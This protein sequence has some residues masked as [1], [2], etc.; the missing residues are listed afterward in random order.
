MAESGKAKMPIVVSAKADEATRQS[1][2]ELAAQL[3]R[4]TGATFITIPGDGTTGI[5]VGTATDFPALV[6]AAGLRAA[7]V[8][9]P[10]AYVLHSHREGIHLVGA[11]AA[12]VRHAVWDLLYIVGFRQFFPGQHWEVVPSSPT[13]RIVVDVRRGPA[14]L[15]RRIVYGFGT[16]PELKDSYQN[17]TI[18]NRMDG[19]VSMTTG[20]AYGQI[21]RANKAQFGQ[22]PEWLGLVGGERKSSKF[23]I[24]N[25][26]LRKFISEFEARRV[27]EN[28]SIES[29]SMEPSDGGGWCECDA[30]AKLGTISDRALLLANDVA[31]AI[32]KIRPGIRV[33]LYAYN[34]HSPPPKTVRAHPS[35]VVSVATAFLRGGNT[36]KSLL[37]SWAAKG[38]SQFG[39][40]EYY[41]VNTWDRDLP[42]HARGGNLKYLAE[43]IPTFYK[44]GARFMTA[45]AGANWGPN[46]LGYYIAAR[47]LWDPAEAARMNEL[48]QDF[49]S[50]AFGP[51]QKAMTS[52]YR[53]LDGSHL[54]PV[55]T[56]LVGRLYRS[57]DEAFHMTQDPAIRARLDDLLLY[58]RYVELFRAYGA[59]RG[60]D[61]QIAFEAL[62]RFSYRI[63]G[64]QMVHSLALYRDLVTRDKTVS[65]PVDAVFS[66][67]EK[68]A[69]ANSR[70]NPWKSS[71]PFTASEMANMLRSGIKANQPRAFATLGFSMDLVPATPLGMMDNTVG[72][73]GHFT[74]G[75]DTFFTWITDPAKPVQ[76]RV[77]GGLIRHYRNRGDVTLTLYPSDDPEG[78]AATEVRLPPDGTERAATL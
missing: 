78:K 9:G 71:E 55:S 47:L 66:V 16:W 64:T 29:V 18:R 50:R 30:C 43:T 42:G 36:P 10:D 8:N 58:V 41:S 54:Q 51:A 27:K 3:K 24:S 49:L 35:V 74:R 48:T 7:D 21:L 76:L 45:E 37:D 20:H 15:S 72:R 61:R 5:A 46:G 68:P 40:R 19:G 34:E 2:S 32:E 59:A 14:F 65:I 52:F 13:L 62:I 63:R 11:T 23:C 44:R 75:R 25:P 70:A 4:I 69:K 33:G 39:I 57:L 26:D 53:L 38:V 56:D 17:W 22:H 6:Y 28:P 60:A 73:F 67:P 77:T 12:A 31:V 1:A